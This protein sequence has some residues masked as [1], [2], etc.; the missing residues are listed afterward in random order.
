MSTRLGEL[1]VKRGGVSAAQLDKAVQEQGQ[2]ALSV[3]LVKLNFINEADLAAVLQKEYRLS[4]VDP[5][6]MNIAADVLRL[7]P[8]TLVQRHH[9]LPISLSGSSLT[10]AMSDPSNLMAINEVKFLTGYDVKVAV[11]CVSAIT[12]A[13]EQYYEKT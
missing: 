3:V 6:V 11:A 1:L 8:V 4:L 12:A 5:S 13:I 7:V 9:L 2:A 10:V